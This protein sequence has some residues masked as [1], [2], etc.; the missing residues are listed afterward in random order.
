MSIIL[1]LLLKRRMQLENMNSTSGGLPGHF[2]F[3]YFSTITH[4]VI[5]Q[6]NSLSFFEQPKQKCKL[7]NKNIHN[8]KL[9]ILVYLDC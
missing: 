5:T 7:L 8:I 6:N 4:V 1:S 3:S 9:K 2:G